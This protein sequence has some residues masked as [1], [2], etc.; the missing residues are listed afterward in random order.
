[1]SE[2]KIT[3]EEAEDL[4]KRW[5]AEAA[6]AEEAKNPK[7]KKIKDALKAGAKQGLGGLGTNTKRLL[8]QIE[9]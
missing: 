5:E 6:K 7:K 3:L 8:D 1:M 4:M 2:P 9:D